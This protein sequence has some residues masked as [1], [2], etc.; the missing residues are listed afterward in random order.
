MTFWIVT[1]FMALA[2]ALLIATV[3]LRPRK[4]GAPAAAFDLKVY[5]QQLRDVDRDLT[6]GVINQGDAKRTRT[7]ISRR[8][9]AADAQVQQN[10]AG[11]AQPRPVTL[12]MAVMAGV[13]ILGGS[14]GLYARLG[15]PTYGDMPLDHRIAQAQDRAN[16]RPSQG[17]AEKGQ[18]AGAALQ[19]EDG[20]A[21]LV[22]QLRQVASARTDDAQGQALLTQHEA[23][24]GNFAAAY[25]AKQNFIR[26][27]SSDVEASDFAETAELMI[28]AAGGYVSPEAE[29]ELRRALMLDTGNGPARYYWGLML[30]QIG[31]PDMAYQIWAETLQAGPAGA[32]WIVGIQEEIVDMARRAGVDYSPI[33]P[34]PGS[35]EPLA[36]PSE[37]LAGPS[38]EDV[39]NAQDMSTQDRQDMIRGMVTRLSARLADE[40]GAPQEWA[41]LIGALGV[42]GELD[43]ARAIHAEALQS[44][45][46]NTAAL[47]LIA[48]AA[49]QAGIM[50]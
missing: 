28:M 34:A 10:S 6:R 37:T 8:I 20:Y 32:A 50:Q 14:I 24:L 31:R 3:L 23:N 5:R 18:P 22:A 25:Q 9:L 12:G 43:R 36:G 47:A 16:N 26:I 35:D 17:D 29:V 40:G 44:F 7:E 13:L 27:M 46:G 48:G 33:T 39:A 30:G 11:Q 1:S 49:Q 45:A 21:Q 41:Q 4:L 38:A 2:I 15:S 19:V 42:L